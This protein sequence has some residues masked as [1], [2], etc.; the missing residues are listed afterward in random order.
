MTAEAKE[1]RISAR[2]PAF[3]K[4]PARRVAE[5]GALEA[6]PNRE[7]TGAQGRIEDHWRLLGGDPQDAPCF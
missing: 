5:H 1:M 2:T 6:Q 7:N 4:D 3:P